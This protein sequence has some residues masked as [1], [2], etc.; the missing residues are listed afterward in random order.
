MKCANFVIFFSFTGSTV[1]CTSTTVKIAYDDDTS[2]Q[3][4]SKKDI[5]T[6]LK[7]KDSYFRKNV[8]CYHG[9][10]F[11]GGGGAPNESGLSRHKYCHWNS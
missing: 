6:F 3:D 2:P 8:A 7:K 10:P 5:R 4:Y 9:S 11:F 1:K